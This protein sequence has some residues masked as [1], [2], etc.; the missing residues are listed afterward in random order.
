MFLIQIWVR[1]LSAILVQGSCQGFMPP[2]S[3]RAFEHILALP[4]G[5]PNYVLKIELEAILL[6]TGLSTCLL[7]LVLISTRA[8]KTTIHL[9]G[10]DQLQHRR[11]FVPKRIFDNRKPTTWTWQNR[12]A[13]HSD[14]DSEFDM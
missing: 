3:E 2:R 10:C 14:S 12:N 6:V 9:L 8:M 13:L 5:I 1:M 7:C 4:N 11:T